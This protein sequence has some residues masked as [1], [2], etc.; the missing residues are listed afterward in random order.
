[1]D[2]TTQTYKRKID[3]DTPE[4]M[5]ELYN[6]RNQEEGIEGKIMT[7][8]PNEKDKYSVLDM[9]LGAALKSLQDNN[10]R[11]LLPPEQKLQSDLELS[12]IGW[13]LNRWM[14][15]EGIKYK[16]GQ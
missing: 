10:R 3:I 7:I 9:D 6:L 1:M 2:G 8:I 14:K 11:D 5:A 12:V 13:Y 4:G 16:V 15:K